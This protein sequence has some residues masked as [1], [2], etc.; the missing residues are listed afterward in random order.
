MR[1]EQQQLQ[2]ITDKL[3]KKWMII[4]KLN[5]K[6]EVK[7]SKTLRKIMF[8]NIIIQLLCV[9]FFPLI[10][11]KRS[12]R[13]QTFFWPC[14]LICLSRFR[15]QWIFHQD[16]TSKLNFLSKNKRLKKKIAPSKRFIRFDMDFIAIEINKKSQKHLFSRGFQ[17]NIIQKHL[18]IKLHLNF[19]CVI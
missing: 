1:N 17:E 15:I 8:I 7:S 10:P 11:K 18:T 4:Q 3:K 12:S 16:S 9:C 6:N 13:C 14:N 2:Q 5:N 19:R